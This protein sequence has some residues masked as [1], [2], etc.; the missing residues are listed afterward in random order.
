MARTVD[1]DV[2]PTERMSY[3]PTTRAYRIHVTPPSG[4]NG[5]IVVL[6]IFITSSQKNTDPDLS[7][8]QVR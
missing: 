1:R 8:V 3:T 7:Q 6:W 2:L 4:G 5:G